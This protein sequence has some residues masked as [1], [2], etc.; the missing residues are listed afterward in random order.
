MVLRSPHP[1][2]DGHRHQDTAA[3]ANEGQLP[4][5][6]RRSMGHMG[7]GMKFEEAC[8]YDLY[9]SCICCRYHVISSL[10]FDKQTRDV[11]Y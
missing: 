3:V 5:K 6:G 11:S 10:Y 9:M 1:G 8:R 7:K 4:G 2:G